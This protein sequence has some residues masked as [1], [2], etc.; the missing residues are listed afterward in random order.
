MVMAS[1][2]DENDLLVLRRT[3]ENNLIVVVHGKDH[4]LVI[5]EMPLKRGELVHSARSLGYARLAMECLGLTFLNGSA[6]P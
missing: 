1:H 4:D 6:T 5:G 3:L 2:F